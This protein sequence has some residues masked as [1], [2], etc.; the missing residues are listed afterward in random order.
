MAVIQFITDNFQ[1]KVIRI[2]KSWCTVIC[3]ARLE[4]LSTGL[5]ELIL[6]VVH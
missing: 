6:S 2:N 3:T 4:L 5:V 1:N